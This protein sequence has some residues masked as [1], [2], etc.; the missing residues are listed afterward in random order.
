MKTQ[1]KVHLKIPSKYQKCTNLMNQ[2]RWL[3]N[4]GV[5]PSHWAVTWEQPHWKVIQQHDPAFPPEI[6]IF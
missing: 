5:T 6:Y 1:E 3:R 4:Y 2:S